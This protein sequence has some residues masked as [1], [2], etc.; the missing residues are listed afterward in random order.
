M[1]V[2]MLMEN[3][4]VKKLMN[5]GEKFDICVLETFNIDA[6]TV[7][8]ITKFRRDQYLIFIQ[9][10]ADHFDCEL[11]SYTTFGAVRWVDDMTGG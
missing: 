8:N 2:E 6:L 1:S 5:S 3:E 10:L 7:R 11:I 9:G 4:D